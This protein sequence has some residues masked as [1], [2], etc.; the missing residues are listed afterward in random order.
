MGRRARPRARRSEQG[1]D[2]TRRR[3]AR[4]ASPAAAPRP[5][6]R[7]RARR[8][9]RSGWASAVVLL[10]VLA[11]LVAAPDRPGPQASGAATPDHDPSGARPDARARRAHRRRTADSYV[12]DGTAARR[13]RCGPSR[14]TSG[15]TSG[16]RSPR[17]APGPPATSRCAARGRALSA[18]AASPGWPCG[19]APSTGPPGPSP[20]PT[21]CS[22]TSGGA[23]TSTPGTGRRGRWWARSTCSPPSATPAWSGC[24]GRCAPGSSATTSPSSPGRPRAGRPRGPIPPAAAT[25]SC[26]PGGT[27]AGVPGWYAGH[28]VPGG[29]DALRRRGHLGPGTASP[30]RAPAWPPA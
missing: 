26:P 23:G 29:S 13:S 24:R 20:S 22:P 11:V 16:S 15:A 30:A 17:A 7:R 6:A 21:T 1:G 25:W 10:V 27:S 28:L 14:A 9:A 4:T 18:T 3:R 5:R 19:C 2:V 8:G 12:V